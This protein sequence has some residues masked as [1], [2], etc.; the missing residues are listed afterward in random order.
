MAELA[1]LRLFSTQ[2]ESKVVYINPVPE[3]CETK[4][5]RWKALFQEQLGMSVGSLIGDLK[6]DLVTIAQNTVIVATPEQMD[7]FTCKGKYLKLIQVRHG[8]W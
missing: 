7:A 2:P 5:A 8:E 3:V 4:A 6:E 1:M